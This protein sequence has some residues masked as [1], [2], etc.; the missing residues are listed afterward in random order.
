VN[1]RKTSRQ[2]QREDA[3]AELNCAEAVAQWYRE[4]TLRFHPDRFGSHEAMTA[5][6]HAH[7]RL[8]QLLGLD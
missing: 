1:R 2:R 6:N 5:I 8:R 7:Q 3:R 4:M